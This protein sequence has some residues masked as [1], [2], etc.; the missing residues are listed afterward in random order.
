[1]KNNHLRAKHWFVLSCSIIAATLCATTLPAAQY[2][3]YYVDP[4]GS[5]SYPGSID[6]PF[7]SIA[8]AQTQIRECINLKKQPMTVY[9]REGVYYL[10]DT[11]VFSAEDSGAP[12][13]TVT[14]SAYK[15]ET[16]VISGGSRLAL[17]W[18][19]YRNGILQAKTSDGLAFDQL[20]VNGKRQRMARYPDFDPDIV[21]YNGFAAN[22]FSPERA[23]NW[24]DPVGGFI[25]AM[26][27]NRWGGYH[28]RITAKRSDNTVIYEGGWQNNRQMGMHKSYRFVEN[29]FEELD[30]PGE[31]FHDSTTQTLYYYPPKGIDPETATIEIARLKTLIEFRGTQEDPVRHI[32]LKG[33]VFRHTARTFMETKEPLLRSDWTIYRGGTVLFNGA[34]DCVV[35]D[36][37]FDQVGGNAV[38]VNNYNR[39]ISLRGTHI[40]S[41]GAS[42]VCFVG[43]P[44]AVRNPLFEYHQRQAYEDIDKT[45]GP[46]TDNH[47]ANCVVDDCLIHDIGVVEKQATGVQISMS[48]SV[49]IRHC[50]IYDVGRAGINISEGTFGGHVIEFCDVFD[51]VRETGDHGSFNSWGRDRYWHLSGVPAGELAELALLDCEKNTIR[52][53]RWRCDRGWDVDLDDGSSNYE[54]YNNVFLH[55]GLKLREGFHRRVWNNIGVNCTLHAHVWYPDSKDELRNNIWLKPYADP[56][57]MPEGK[58]GNQNDFN[59]FTTRA[60]REKAVAFGWDHHSLVGDPMFVDAPN[61]DYRVRPESPALKLGFKNFPMDEFG[62]RKAELKTIARVPKFPVLKSKKPPVATVGNRVEQWLGASVK[63]LTGEQFSAFGV[64]QEEGGIHLVSVPTNSRLHLA[65]LVEGDLVQRINGKPVATIAAL[66]KKTKDGAGKPLKIEFVRNQEKESLIIDP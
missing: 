20:F 42:G 1:M 50:S 65:G 35:A 38:F 59:L 64:R 39:R 14:Y 58:W 30:A 5:D 31:W 46:K 52:N 54:I 33:L 55:G 6:Q 21:P 34:E 27:R 61:G 40:H 4:N 45:R 23:A 37:E 36:C 12:N 47:P 7:R 66:H 60:A 15:G 44:Q 17:T 13:A 29:I 43:D 25:H 62:V 26:H 56:I 16:A 49:T 3:D 51:T 24:A 22:A 53:S 57:R 11:V 48:R 8:R 18:K 10:D 28:Y 32:N 63:A 9:L 19:P 2:D 41:A